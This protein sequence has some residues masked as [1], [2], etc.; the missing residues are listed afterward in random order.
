M[1]LACFAISR[2][3]STIKLIAC[4]CI[5]LTWIASVRTSASGCEEPESIEVDTEIHHLRSLADREWDSFPAEAEGSSLSYTVRLPEPQRDWTLLVRQSDVKQ[6]WKLTCNDKLLGELVQ[7]ENDL[8]A[9]FEI[10]RDFISDETIALKF[11]PQGTHPT[12]DDIRLGE[13]RL[14]ASSLKESLSPGTLEVKIT[15]ET[16]GPIP[17]RITITDERGVLVPIGGTE[18]SNKTAVRSG[19]VFTIAPTTTIS[20]PLGTYHITAGRGF[21]YSL[22]SAQVVIDAGASETLTLSIEREVDTTGFIACDPHVHTLTYSGHGDASVQERMIT[23]AGEG[24]E[25]PIAT[26]HNVFVDHRPFVD[27]VGVSEFL[28]PVIGNEV[29]TPVGHFNIFPAPA[30]AMSPDHRLTHWEPLF[31]SI[32]ETTGAPIIILNHARDLH[33]GVRPFGPKHF[34]EVVGENQDGWPMGFNAMEIINSSATQSDPLQLTRDWMTLLNRGLRITPV[35]SSDSHDVLRHFVGQG[36]TYIQCDDAS[37][38]SIDI[39]DAVAAFVAEKVRV[40]YGLLVEVSIKGKSSGETVAVEKGDLP[41]EVVVRATH[42]IKADRLELFLNGQSHATIELDPL[43]E[44]IENGILWRGEAV[45]SSLSHDVNVVAVA[46]GPGVDA[47]H[48]RA[49][50]PYQSTSPSWTPRL[51]G[52]S[53]VIRL[54]VDGNGFQSARDY[55]ER[56]WNE[57]EGDLKRLMIA[58]RDYDSITAS[59]IAHQFE[60]A[61]GS[62]TSPELEAAIDEAHPMVQSGFRAY[63]RASEAVARAKIDPQE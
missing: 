27:E 60:L 63:Q 14:V 31:A 17:G 43:R 22:A 11:E 23:L 59:H 54:D 15:D 62:W 29:T 33:S 19:T 28:T 5:V 30:N 46:T 38:G 39:D 50:K 57:S 13:I 32:R 4:V 2:H 26:D 44:P 20:L 48:W 7:D 25:L 3:H 40:S 45:L 12:S 55:A 56:L 9:A 35:G 18:P 34:H 49:A 41:I 53:G 61:H 16:G 42:W 37:P 8:V 21:E 52:V 1:N 47:P 58:A 10:K 6:R 24:I 51:I 36:R